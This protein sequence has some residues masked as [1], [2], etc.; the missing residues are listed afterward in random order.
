[1]I[2]MGLVNNIYMEVDDY[3]SISKEVQQFLN[4]N[5]GS[6][7]FKEAELL[8]VASSRFIDFKFSEIEQLYWD[9]INQETLKPLNKA[10]EDLINILVGLYAIA[11]SEGFIIDHYPLPEGV[12]NSLRTKAMVDSSKVTDDMVKDTKVDNARMKRVSEDKR[13]ASLKMDFGEVSTGRLF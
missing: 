1:V 7:E 12:A 4:D 8:R 11:P 9:N 3:N 6:L 2:G 5:K 13:K 10:S